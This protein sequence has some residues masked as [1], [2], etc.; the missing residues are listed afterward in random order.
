MEFVYPFNLDCSSSSRFFL[1]APYGM[2]GF[3]SL[4]APTVTLATLQ[5]RSKRPLALR[6]AFQVSPC[7]FS[8]PILQVLDSTFFGLRGVFTRSALTFLRTP[9]S[10]EHRYHA[11]PSFS[12]PFFGFFLTF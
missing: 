6:L 12:P 7:F 10:L 1:L 8:F 9:F 5:C 4:G 11:T 2:I 3:F